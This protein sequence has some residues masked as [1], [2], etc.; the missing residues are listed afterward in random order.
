MTLDRLLKSGPMESDNS[1]GDIVYVSERREI[2][3]DISEILKVLWCCDNAQT[4]E[5]FLAS[6]V[7]MSWWTLST[8][9]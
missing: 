5:S 2:L 8:R 1:T 9:R 7:Q 4:N 6:V 3:P